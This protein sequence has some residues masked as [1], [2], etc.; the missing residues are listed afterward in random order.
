MSANRTP[1]AYRL[2]VRTPRHLWAV[3]CRTVHSPDLAVRLALLLRDLLATEDIEFVHAAKWAFDMRDAIEEAG[4]KCR[5]C[6]VLVVRERLPGTRKIV[7][8]P[9]TLIEFDVGN[10]PEGV[11]GRVA[12]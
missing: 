5:D 11:I 6:T 10:A 9:R 3:N 12:R 2:L 7:A 1:A 4:L 8:Q